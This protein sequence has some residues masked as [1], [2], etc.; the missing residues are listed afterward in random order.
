MCS[1]GLFGVAVDGTTIILI[2]TQL[3]WGCFSC[4]ITSVL[5]LK[6]WLGM[7][8]TNMFRNSVGWWS[9]CHTRDML[10]CLSIPII[11]QYV[12]IVYNRTTYMRTT[13][14]SEISAGCQISLQGSGCGASRCGEWS[15]FGPS[16]S[17]WRN[18][19]G[20][21]RG[22]GRCRGSGRRSRSGGSGGCFLCGGRGIFCHMLLSVFVILFYSRA[23]A[24]PGR[25]GDTKVVSVA[26]VM[27]LLCCYI[28]ILSLCCCCCCCWWWWWWWWCRCCS[29]CLFIYWLNYLFI[30]NYWL[31]GWF[32]CLLLVLRA[33]KEEE[34]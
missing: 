22:A 33:P 32:R 25:A 29:Y 4:Q 1:Y 11:Q 30:Y 12:H 5:T 14:I 20:S 9:K 18:A 19:G 31:F 34:M 2:Q 24:L 15:C 28:V 27:L 16:R 10:S 13:C 23:D 17:W 7:L 21:S 8:S 26:V 6:W 3:S